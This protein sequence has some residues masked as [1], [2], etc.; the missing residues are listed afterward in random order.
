MIRA[1]RYGSAT[2]VIAASL[3]AAPA[4]A[5]STGSQEFEEIVVTGTRTAS[6]GVIVADQAPKARS[7]IDQ[8]Y[9]ADKF[10]GQSILDTL[11]LTPGYNFVNNDP[12]GNS[13]GNLRL[14]GLDGAR[15]ALLQDGIPLND[16][17]NYSI[18]SNQ[19]LDSELIERAVVNV[20]TTDVDSPTAAATGGT[21][22]YITRKPRD[23]MGFM[24]Q[25]SLGENKYYRGIGVLDTGAFGPWGTT[26]FLSASYTDYDKWKGPGDLT[27][28]QY[29][30]RI[31]Q[32]IGSNGDFISVMA[33]YNRNRN[34]FY[35]N[36]RLSEFQTNRF[37]DRVNFCQRATPGAGTVQ[38]ENT[39][40]FSACGST[41]IGQDSGYAN[42]F[43]NPSNTGNI[44]AQG[45]F[46]LTDGLTLTVDPS[47]QYVLANGGGNEVVAETDPR[48]QG[49]QY[50]GTTAATR[51]ARGVDLNGDGDILDSIRLYRP[52]NTNTRRF[53]VNSSLIWNINDENL[54]RVAYTFDRA[55]HRQTGEFGFLTSAG[56]PQNV[57]GGRNGT[58]VLTLDGTPLQNRDRLSIALLNQLA[59]EYRGE[60]FD[61]FLTVSLGVRAPFFKRELNQYCFTIAQS[62]ST[63][64][65]TQASGGGFA[66]CS[67]QSEASYVAAAGAST[68]TRLNGV[69]D[70]GTSTS[71][72]SGVTDARLRRPFSTEVKYDKVLPNLGVSI[73]PGDGHLVFAGYSQN[74]SA[75]RTDDLYDV[76]LP[77]ST[78]ET[79]ELIEVGYRYQKGKILSAIGAYTSTFKNRLVR[80]FDQDQGINITRN[81]GKVDFKG[82]DGQVGYQITPEISLYGS[83]SYTDTEVKSD[84]ILGRN[85]AG[86]ATLLPTQG[87]Q[88]VETPKYQWGARAEYNGDLIS[89]G[90]ELKSVGKRAASDTNDEFSPAYQT[91]NLNVRLKLEEWTGLDGSYLQLNA[92]NLFNEKYLGNINS[93]TNVNAFTASN[94]VA[95]GGNFPT[96]SVGSPQT[97]QAT[98]RLAF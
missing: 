56:D 38:N 95:V 20:G 77:T 58:P 98:L 48:L 82:V 36:L 54:F 67:R 35:R 31:Y 8:A 70:F 50:V 86:V 79:T 55:R 41:T 37:I 44:R 42:L 94:G 83:F 75:P 26:A 69:V 30:A 39:A 3:L 52:N 74:L 23:E 92:S 57:F 51:I 43:I 6:Q 66:Y 90:I 19:Q 64:G 65:V 5:Q 33:H 2:A 81:V 13:G 46:T 17:G 88:L 47:F 78:P 53:G 89:G 9:I 7:I 71:V 84:V 63:P 80:S 21:I 34:N 11:N 1:L 68:A 16:S 14:R 59:A 29:N 45:R 49:S 87:K 40:P 4:F 91:V 15:I 12:Y 96:Y 22:N 73:K 93:V 25:G 60:F 27:K 85:A 18:F 72:G 28:Q 32:P 62:N 24:G 76:Q 97:F 10:A 61:Q